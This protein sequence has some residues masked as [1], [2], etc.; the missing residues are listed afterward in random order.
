ML[1]LLTGAAI[2]GLVAGGFVP[3]PADFKVDDLRKLFVRVAD[4]DVE[5]RAIIRQRAIIEDLYNKKKVALEDLARRAKTF[6]ERQRC[7]A[8]YQKLRNVAEMAD[9]AIFRDPC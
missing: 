1:K 6:D 5:N 8:D 7:R 3:L 2:A 4:L 9:L